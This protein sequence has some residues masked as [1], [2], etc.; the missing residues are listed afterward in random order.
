MLPALR[1]S[2]GLVIGSGIQVRQV[3]RGERASEPVSRFTCLSSAAIQSD[4]CNSQYIIIHSPRE[5]ARNDLIDWPRNPNQGHV[6]TKTTRSSTSSTDARYLGVTKL[7]SIKLNAL[8]CTVTKMPSLM[9]DLQ[10]Q[11]LIGPNKRVLRQLTMG[12]TIGCRPL[13]S[14]EREREFS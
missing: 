11:F 3:K 6:R 4:L 1:F 2:K 5:T 8:P 13:F 10:T 14:K 12:G 9:L 7:M